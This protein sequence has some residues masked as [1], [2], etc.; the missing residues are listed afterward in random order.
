MQLFKSEQYIYL[1]YTLKQIIVRSHFKGTFYRNWEV[2]LY[3]SKKNLA[4]FMMQYVPPIIYF[5]IN[6]VF[7][8]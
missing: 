5:T 3:A 7:Y 4:C 8:I 2:K 1:L 6:R